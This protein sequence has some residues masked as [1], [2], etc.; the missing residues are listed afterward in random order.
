MIAS[1]SP[2]GFITPP[3]HPASRHPPALAAALQP[4]RLCG[5]QHGPV[6]PLPTGEFSATTGR[7]GACARSPGLLNIHWF[8][9]QHLSALDAGTARRVYHSIPAWR[10]KPI[11]QLV[12]G[13]LFAA[14]CDV[15]LEGAAPFQ[16]GLPLCS[17]PG[18]AA[19][20]SC[21]FC[22]AVRWPCCPG[23][24]AT[25]RCCPRPR[26]WRKWGRKQLC[27]RHPSLHSLLVAQLPG[28]GQAAQVC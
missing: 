22:A 26:Q 1:F 25:P 24:H 20:G 2:W 18:Q 10:W 7:T 21:T 14:T 12:T 3:G 5:G 17:F 19:G 27:E 8:D 6:A 13:R 9:L 15:A 16:W 11:M 28:A 23:G 4:Q